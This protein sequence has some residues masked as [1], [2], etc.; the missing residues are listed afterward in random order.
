MRRRNGSDRLC[1]YLV[2]LDAAMAPADLTDLA[3]Y[4]SSLQTAGCEVVVLDPAEG[5]AL[6][7]NQR[8]L[9]WV[10]EHVVIRREHLGFG[11]ELDLLRA[12]SVVASCEK[13]IIASPE[14]RHT[15]GSL[16]VICELLDRHEVVDPQDYIDPLPWWG[17]LE[18]AGMLLQ[19]GIDVRSGT[20]ATFGLRRGALRSLPLLRFSGEPVNQIERLADAGADVLDA[21]NVL[22]R[23]Q[24]PAFRRWLRDRVSIAAEDFATAPRAL[25]F[26]SILP[27]LTLMA[28]LGGPAF[29]AT[30]AALLSGGALVIAARGRSN[31]GHAFPF[32]TCLFAPLAVFERSVSIY[33]ALAAR[34]G[35]R[36]G[37]PAP[38]TGSRSSGA[39]AAS[40]E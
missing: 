39:R 37:T 8:V 19:R 23:R 35:Q 9:R 11:G 18:A 40:G 31:A 2:A 13:I 3:A 32:R 1:T 36:G 24:A 33:L 17:G 22:V 25:L 34:L 15:A 21:R 28:I 6:E 27:L 12:A 4:L 14:V 26:F 20:G 30:S 5:N 29:A 10:S 7:R 16:A 38:A